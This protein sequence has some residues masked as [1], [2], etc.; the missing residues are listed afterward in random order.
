[1]RE[2]RDPEPAEAPAN[3]PT[4][5]SRD[6]VTTSKV[7]NADSY[8]RCASCGEVWNAARLKA[9]TRYRRDSPFQR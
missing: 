7:A 4:C 3:C 9:G 2:T 8:W 5:R 6:V 1:M